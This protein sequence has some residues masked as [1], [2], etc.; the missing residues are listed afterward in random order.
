[1]EEGL[2]EIKEH[3]LIPDKKIIEIINE[4]NSG[5]HIILAG[6]IGTG[7]TELA[8]TIPKLFLGYRRRLLF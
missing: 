5:S 3:F 2:Q 7:K 1:M 6:P 4:L 8:R